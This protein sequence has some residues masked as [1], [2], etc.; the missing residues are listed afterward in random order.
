MVQRRQAPGKGLWA[1]P[2]GFLDGHETIQAAAI[3]ELKEETSILVPEDVLARS[4]IGSR[5]FDDPYRSARG[6]TITTVF[7]MD[8]S[9]YEDQHPV[10]HAADDAAEAKW[11]PVNEINP[12]FPLRGFVNCIGTG[13]CFS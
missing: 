12:D 11:V 9:D 6:R 10:V 13:T 5:T 4:I 1:L 8:V 3:R 7:H 2:G